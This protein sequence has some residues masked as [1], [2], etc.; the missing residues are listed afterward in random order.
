[1]GVAGTR[2][3]LENNWKKAEKCDDSIKG[4]HQANRRCD[5]QRIPH[6]LERAGFLIRGYPSSSGGRVAYLS[7][8]PDSIAHGTSVLLARHHT[9]P[10]VFAHGDQHVSPRGVDASFGEH[11][12]SVGIRRGRGRRVGAFSISHL[13][14][15]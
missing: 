14:L 2:P 13:L 3:I 7:V 11:A 1:M 12:L 6:P 8:W 9:Q 4:R 10:S 5:L 15:Y